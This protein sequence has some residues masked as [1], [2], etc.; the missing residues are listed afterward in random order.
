[1]LQQQQQQQQQHHCHIVVAHSFTSCLIFSPICELRNRV[2]G[3]REEKTTG[4]FVRRGCLC[5]VLVQGFVEGRQAEVG[6]LH[7]ETAVYDTVG[8]TQVAVDL[9]V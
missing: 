8:G 6:D 1:M 7:G 2:G 4:T 9:D 3:E 5:V